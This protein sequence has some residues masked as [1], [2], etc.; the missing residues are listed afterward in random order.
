MRKLNT[1]KT[2]LNNRRDNY[3]QLSNSL[4]HLMK[5][6]K[7]FY[8]TSIG[9][10]QIFYGTKNPTRYKICV[11]TCIYCWLVT[12]GQIVF[13][14]CDQIYSKFDGP[15]LPDNFK[16]IHVMAVIAFALC[17]LIKAELLIGEKKYNLKP[18]RVFYSL[19]NNWK[20]S[21]IKHNL[22]VKNYKRLAYL[23]R[24]SQ[25]L[26]FDYLMPIVILMASLIITQ[27]AFLS[28]QL[29]WFL[30]AIHLIPLYM[31]IIYG[32]STG[33]VIIYVYFSYYKMIFDQINVKIKEMIQNGRWRFII[34]RR[35]DIIINLIQEHNQLANAIYQMN[36][37]FR[38]I[39][40]AMFI[41]VSFIKIISLYL[42]I[43]MKR[44]SL[45]RMLI[46]NIFIVSFFFSYLIYYFL[47]HQIK[48]AHHSHQFVHSIVCKY[49]MSLNLR[50]KLSNFIDR[51]TGPS[52]GLYCYDI[53]PCDINTFCNVILYL[54]KVIKSIIN[55]NIFRKL[56]LPSPHS[57]YFTI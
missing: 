11:L 44:V 25:T 17:S 5:I 37:I 27:T 35:E 18:L 6:S 20:F 23:T 54:I 24:I 31:W 15:F 1:I 4:G 36:L 9:F 47:S 28:G 29:F 21:I 41:T 52:I 12:I 39:A 26:V 42:L 48:S 38:R 3:F 40:A 22:N 53:A 16:T 34:G 2:S 49:K 51:L 55:F 32:F 56:T 7:R 14:S 30:Q 19:M 10:D 33:F 8:V 50:L 57:F 13:I 43:Y 45:M 46:A